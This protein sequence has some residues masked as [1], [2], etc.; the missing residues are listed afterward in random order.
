LVVEDRINNGL[1]RML[2]LIRK[3]GTAD[4]LELRLRIKDRRPDSNVSFR[5]NG[6]RPEK[7]CDDSGI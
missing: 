4:V 3:A 6:A 5:N 1:M 7:S 2:E